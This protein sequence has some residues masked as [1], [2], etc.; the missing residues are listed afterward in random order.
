MGMT[1]TIVEKDGTTP[2]MDPKLDAYQ[3]MARLRSQGRGVGLL[4]EDGTFA[5]SSDGLMTLKF[6]PIN[7]RT[8]R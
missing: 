5:V 8:K 2:S 4:V 1:F 6:V 3:Y 7:W